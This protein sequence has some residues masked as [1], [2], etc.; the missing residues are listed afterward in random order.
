[1]SKATN[2]FHLFLIQ[3]FEVQKGLETR[4]DKV[5]NQAVT[6]IGMVFPSTIYCRFLQTVDLIA[7]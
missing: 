7:A 2:L 6:Q 5:I 1:M 3:M 4:P